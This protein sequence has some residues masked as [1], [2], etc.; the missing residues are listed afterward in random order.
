MDGRIIQNMKLLIVSVLL[1]LLI[2]YKIS[3]LNAYGGSL[4]DIVLHLF[5]NMEASLISPFL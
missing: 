5:S 1:F 4:F 2:T 3:W